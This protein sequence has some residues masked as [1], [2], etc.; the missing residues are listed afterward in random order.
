[1]G[2]TLV[3]GNSYCVFAREDWGGT[4]RFRTGRSLPQFQF[5]ALIKAVTRARKR[6]LDLALMLIPYTGN[7]RVA[8][9][10][11]SVLDPVLSHTETPAF[12]KQRIALMAICVL[13]LTQLTRK[14][15]GINIA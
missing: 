3:V 1:M 4:M 7:D 6:R 14:I 11:S 12:N 9:G 2:G 13:P 10:A 15:S 5:T 8:R